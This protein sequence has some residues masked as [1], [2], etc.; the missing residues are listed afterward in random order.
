MA[1]KSDA[2]SKG[3]GT[4]RHGRRREIFGVLM[5]AFSLFAGLSLLSMQLGG[6]RLMGPGG[7][8]TAA[9]LYALAGFGAYLFIAAL[10]LGAVRC[11]RSARLVSGVGEGLGALMLL[12]SAAVLMHLPFADSRGVHGGPGGMLGEWLGEVTASFIGA[13]G[14]ALAAATVLMLAL[15]ILCDF[16]M[17]EVVVVVGWALRQAQRGVVAGLGAVWRLARA[18]FPERAEESDETEAAL[19]ESREDIKVIAASASAPALE[20][21]G[22]DAYDEEALA[23]EREAL[24]AAAQDVQDADHGSENE[25][26]SDEGIRVG[27]ARALS[28]EIADERA[29]MAA[30]VAEVA[31]VEQVSPPP[32]LTR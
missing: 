14:A 28:R 25:S 32:E 16:S 29:A 12:L 27:Q 10:G 13:V 26:D 31:A 21:I 11:F 4:T 15:M 9:G 19:E 8:A 5:L 24:V 1:A 3:K 30:I 2:E 20:P 17:S 22:H 18:A 7:A 6:N 23:A